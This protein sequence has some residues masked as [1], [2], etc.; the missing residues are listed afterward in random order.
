MSLS[1]FT[2][3]IQPDTWNN[4]TMRINKSSGA[5][6]LSMNNKVETTTADL[7]GMNIGEQISVGTEN[8]SIF[9]KNLTAH[10]DDIRVYSEEITDEQIEDEIQ[11][12]DLLKIS[13][14]A[15]ISAFNHTISTTNGATISGETITFDGSSS[16]V[17]VDGAKLEGYN[18][19]Q[20]TFKTHVNP[21]NTNGGVLMHK[22]LDYNGFIEVRLNAEN[23]LEIEI[24]DKP[25]Y[26]VSATLVDSAVTV[27]GKTTTNA[28]ATPTIYSVAYTTPQTDKS[29]IYN[30][31]SYFTN[32]TPLSESN[33][34]D[35]DPSKY[36]VIQP[37]VG[38][39]I[40]DEL[41]HTYRG[42]FETFAT[43]GSAIGN[44]GI[45][46]YGTNYTTSSI[47]SIQQ[48]AN[49]LNYLEML[50]G[51]LNV[52]FAT[53][54]SEVNHTF[55]FVVRA[56]DVNGKIHR[57]IK[58]ISMTD[59]LNIYVNYNGAV[60]TTGLYPFNF[61]GTGWK[62][63]QDFNPQDAF[64]IVVM[65]VTYP[66]STTANV[67]IKLTSKPTDTFITAEAN[68]DSVPSQSGKHA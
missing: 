49:G 61:T 24:S 56:A 8:N 45:E 20:F 29:A 14:V 41:T 26:D 57:L 63:S 27:S 46:L 43:G 65:K 52:P 54:N 59:G 16:T 10:V 19:N 31:I 38:P 5:V 32:D 53:A 25:V 21:S 18:L 42:S 44:S 34:L 55:Y 36:S 6:K 51:Q 22:K 28:G 35:L 62:F 1:Q 7:T 37:T 17:E 67:R 33:I 9:T 47:G 23:K 11:T 48:D 50:T 30:D 2:D 12:F 15:D 64:C 68:E 60:N 3:T 39:T 4:I 58:S 66:T 40:I 13:G